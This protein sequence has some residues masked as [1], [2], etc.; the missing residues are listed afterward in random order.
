MQMN[1][2]VQ[3]PMHRHHFWQDDQAHSLILTLRML[4]V[5][6]L[7]LQHN[8][9]MKTTFSP[10]NAP[11]CLRAFLASLRSRRLPDIPITKLSAFEE[12]GI[13]YCCDDTETGI[14]QSSRVRISTRSSTDD[15]EARQL[16]STRVILSIQEWS[17]RGISFV[18]L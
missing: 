3:S 18:M 9:G 1:G 12:Y 14:P 10:Q 15:E 5:S 16:R 11:R 13:C 2:Y 7:C 8:I 6:D 17:H 4:S